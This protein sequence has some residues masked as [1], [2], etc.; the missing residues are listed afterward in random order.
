MVEQ[1]LRKV[2]EGLDTNSPGLMQA[3]TC[4]CEDMMVKPY[5]FPIFGYKSAKEIVD[6]IREI[7]MTEMPF[8]NPYPEEKLPF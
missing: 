4:I 3:L 7:L 1:V 6:K 8:D 2:T 5:N